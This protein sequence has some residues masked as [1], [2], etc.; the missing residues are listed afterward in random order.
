MKRDFPSEWDATIAA[1]SS[2]ALVN[3]TIGS[4]IKPLSLAAIATQLQGSGRDITKLIVHEDAADSTEYDRDTEA[5]RYAYRQLGDL[6]LLR[7]RRIGSD[8]PAVRGV[9]MH[10]YLTRSRT[11]PAVV[12]GTIGLVP[13][14]DQPAKRNAALTRLFAGPPNG[15]VSFGDRSVGFR[16]ATALRDLWVRNQSGVADPNMLAETALFRGIEDCYGPNVAPFYLSENRRWGDDLE[17]N[18]LFPLDL[19]VAGSVPLRARVLPEPHWADATLTRVMDGQLMQYMFGGGE[20]RWNAVTMAANMA[21]ITS[22]VRV[23]PTLRAD[24]KPETAAMPAPIS[25]TAWRQANLLSPLL[26]ITTLDNATAVRQAVERHGYRIAMKT[27]T[28]DDSQGMDSE[29]LMFTIGPYTSEKGFDAARSVSGFLSVRSSK[30]SEGRDYV[31]GALAERVVK[32]IADH[33]AENGAK[34]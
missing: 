9:G 13:S 17:S 18:F 11:W 12:S 2:W 34:R 10:E 27:G 30:P 22:G 26:S 7:G 20:N 31:K 24:K 6:K 25:S 14:A 33:L 19:H 5:M 29:M 15:F 1:S 32:I 21:R 4:A 28:I 3:R 16:P 23:Q 8:L